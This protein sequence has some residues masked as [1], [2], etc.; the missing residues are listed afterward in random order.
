MQTWNMTGDWETEAR[1]KAYERYAFTESMKWKFLVNEWLTPSNK[2]W[3]KNRTK[4]TQM[5]NEITKT[6]KRDC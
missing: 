5:N 3:S 1:N 4:H 6:L 2:P